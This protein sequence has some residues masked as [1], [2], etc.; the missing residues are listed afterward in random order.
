MEQT[1]T[2]KSSLAVTHGITPTDISTK[3]TKRK[4]VQDDSKIIDNNAHVLIERNKEVSPPNSKDQMRKSSLVLSNDTTTLINTSTK[5]IKRK[6]AENDSKQQKLVTTDNTITKIT[7]RKKVQVNPKVMDNTIIL[8]EKNKKVP[9]TNSKNSI[10]PPSKVKHTLSK[11]TIGKKKSEPVTVTSTS[12]ITNNQGNSSPRN[13][14]STNKVEDVLESLQ[15]E[16]DTA[17]NGEFPEPLQS[18]QELL[19]IMDSQAA[20]EYQFKMP[21]IPSSSVLDNIKN[22][23]DAESNEEEL[24]LNIAPNSTQD[25]RNILMDSQDSVVDNSNTSNISAKKVTPKKIFKNQTRSPSKKPKF[26]FSLENFFDEGSASSEKKRASTSLK[27]SKK[28]T[29]PRNSI[30]VIVPS[31]S[32]CKNNVKSRKPKSVIKE[33]VPKQT[34]DISEIVS[35]VD[36]SQLMSQYSMTEDDIIET[37]YDVCTAASSSK[38]EPLVHEENNMEDEDIG[39]LKELSQSYDDSCALVINEEPLEG[40]EDDSSP[41]QSTFTNSSFAFI[42]EDQ[43]NITFDDEPENSATTGSNIATRSGIKSF[44]EVQDK[45]K[46]KHAVKTKPIEI[47]EPPVMK[48][49]TLRRSKRSSESRGGCNSNNFNKSPFSTTGLSYYCRSVDES[50]KFMRTSLKQEAIASRVRPTLKSAVKTKAVRQVNFQTDAEQVQFDDEATSCTVK[51]TE[52]QMIKLNT[53]P[54]VFKTVSMENQSIKHTISDMYRTNAG[55]ETHLGDNIH[56]LCWLCNWLPQQNINDH[57]PPVY[58]GIPLDDH[59][60]GKH[61][62]SSITDYYNTLEPLLYYQVWSDMFSQYARDRR[63]RIFIL[64][65]DSVEY[66]PTTSIQSSRKKLYRLKCTIKNATSKY[67]SEKQLLHLTFNPVHY[68]SYPSF[69]CFAYV[70]HIDKVSNNT[71]FNLHMTLS[72][73]SEKDLTVVPTSED[74]NAYI[75]TKVDINHYK[76]LPRR[77]IRSHMTPIFLN[78]DSVIEPMCPIK[79]RDMLQNVGTCTLKQKHVVSTF[80]DVCLERNRKLALVDGLA[81]TGNYYLYQLE[82]YTLEYLYRHLF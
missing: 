60:K 31:T 62:Y 79:V 9:P 58:K 1:L 34:R 75:L 63:P 33:Q 28:E 61:S 44:E 26:N 40:V 74:I 4:K 16:N 51:H 39:W 15:L 17:S 43:Q 49:D 23:F 12:C 19:S 64:H 57:P 78:P 42:K 72:V 6:K 80:L 77:Y 11:V 47:V 22:V 30:G 65:K 24:D 46:T 66:V 7:K 41:R 56:V 36:D 38:M 18:T 10:L 70:N 37:M 48:S 67:L 73:V 14:R 20:P 45:I 76:M 13:Q 29:I 53:N 32:K 81:G 50:P 59:A 3:P 25:L 8:C 21:S 55:V 82:Q 27:M 5:L 68:E 2:R 71:S 54:S 52:R 69:E 35:D